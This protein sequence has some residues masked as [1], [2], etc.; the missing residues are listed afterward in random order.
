MNT[1]LRRLL[2]IA[3]KEKRTIIGLMS[4]TSLD[5]LD[6][7]LCEF[8]GHGLQT[9]LVLRQF[10]TMP[11]GSEFKQQVKEVFS[12]RAVDLEKVTLMNAYIGSFH[13]ELINACLQEWGLTA[14]DVDII[15]SHGQ[16]IYHA[17]ASQHQVAGMPNAT[18]QI[19]DGDH[20]AVKTGVITLSDFRQKHIAAGGEGAPLAVYGDFLLFSEKGQNRIMLNIGGIAN[21]TF[22]PGDLDTSRIFSTDVG[23]GNTIM[24]AYMQANFPGTFYDAGSAV[25]LQG[26][27]HEG[28]LAAL[29]AHPF[30]QGDF[31]KTTGPEVFNLAYLARAQEASSTTALSAQ[32]VMATLNRFSAHGIC[33]ALRRTMEEEEFEIFVSGGGM[34]NPLL[35]RNIETLLP[36]VVIRDTAELGVSPDA[37]EAVLFATLANECLVG[38]RLDF[39]AGR[40][41]IPAVQMGKISLPQ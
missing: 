5:G 35:R 23:P 13:A 30:F 32:D 15:A 29:L 24:D 36:G 21:F 25:A 18:L 8:T 12:K 34:H 20:I 16:T 1:G 33:D 2:T 7:A 9:Q 10:A 26:T 22:L 4:G 19:G 28:L 27:I 14:Q 31:P 6:I 11:Y 41:R 38:E 40:L 3:E 37:K 17:P 39:G